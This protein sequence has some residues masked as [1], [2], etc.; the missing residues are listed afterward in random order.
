MDRG[1]WSAHGLRGCPVVVALPGGEGRVL[2]VPS[3]TAALAKRMIRRGRISLSGRAGYTGHGELCFGEDKYFVW[4]AGLEKV[5]LPRT[6]AGRPRLPGRG[7]QQLGWAGERGVRLPL[8]QGGDHRFCLQ[9]RRRVTC[10]IHRGRLEV[11]VQSIRTG[12]SRQQM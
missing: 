3:P 7:E 1:G 11:G 8:L 2:P 5:G 6:G 4:A 10:Q 9:G 12:Q